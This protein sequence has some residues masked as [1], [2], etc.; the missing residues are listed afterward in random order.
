[1]ASC[2]LLIRT[3]RAE[4]KYGRILAVCHRI[5]TYGYSVVQKNL[6]TNTSGPGAG[7]PCDDRMGSSGSHVS[8]IRQIE[9]VTAFSMFY[10]IL[11]S[12]IYIDICTVFP[13]TSY[14]QSPNYI[15]LRSNARS[16]PARF[17]ISCASVVSASKRS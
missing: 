4:L 14:E 8:N 9:C 15:N 3:C 7:H 12:L 6:I 10:F 16:L 2:C 11:I 17:Q 13:E 5:H 1:M